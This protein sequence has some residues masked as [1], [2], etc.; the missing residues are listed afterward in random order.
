ME[1]KIRY[2][3]AEKTDHGRIILS[4][5]LQHSM[6]LE[7]NCCCNGIRFIEK[8]ESRDDTQIECEY[9]TAIYA[10]MNTTSMH[11]ILTTPRTKHISYKFGG[12]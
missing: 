4:R 2:V 9:A 6:A 11:P 3:R 10:N 12:A 8:R 5:P 1:N 7:Y